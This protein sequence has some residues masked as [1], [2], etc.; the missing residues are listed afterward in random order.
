MNASEYQDLS[1]RT[2]NGLPQLE[3]LAN[4]GMGVAGEAGEVCD[5]LKKVCFHGHM[6]NIEK[7]A[8]ELGD[9]LFYVAAIATTAG[10]NLADIMA[11]NIDK[12]RRRYPSGFSEERSRRREG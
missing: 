5:Y 8:D 10:L 12:L 11:G 6:L 9:V 1:K 4:Y 3:S 2:M 7:V